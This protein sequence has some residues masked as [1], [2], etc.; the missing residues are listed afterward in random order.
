MLLLT[1]T[2]TNILDVQ[3]CA[4]ELNKSNDTL[5]HS[6]AWAKR[7]KDD[8]PEVIM[9]V[10]LSLSLSS[11]SLFALNCSPLN[12]ERRAGRDIYEEGR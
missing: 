11:S 2:R 12:N 5:S 3:A 10:R 7:V 4:T 8:I 9:Q 6:H 1:G